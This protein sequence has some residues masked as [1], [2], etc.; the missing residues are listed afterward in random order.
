MGDDG[1]DQLTTT[2]QWTSNNKFLDIYTI[3][4]ITP[5][6]NV[7][8]LLNVLQRHRFQHQNLLK[9]KFV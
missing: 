7:N 3:G 8:N 6:H 9:A 4:S 1:L 2:S 5:Y